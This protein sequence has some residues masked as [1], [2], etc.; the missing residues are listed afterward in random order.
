MDERCCRAMR[1]IAKELDLSRPFKAETAQG[2]A[3]ASRN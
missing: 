3:A 1:E 2:A